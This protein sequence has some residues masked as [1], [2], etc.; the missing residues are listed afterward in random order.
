MAYQRIAIVGKSGS[1]K[2]TLA[3]QVAE[4][5]SLPH[6]ELDAIHCQANW[7]HP[8]RSEMRAQVELEL[9]S[10]P[11]WIADGNYLSSVQDIVW[12]RADTLIW[13]DYPLHV[14]L[15]RLLK[16]TYIRLFGTSAQRELWNGN[17]ETL[18]HHLTSGIW[19]NLFSWSTKM[20]Y[21]MRRDFP[22]LLEADD[23]KHLTVLRFRNSNETEKWLQALSRKKIE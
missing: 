16:R 7:T 4:K 5:L 6:I 11:R 23:F 12:S 10:K 17:H 9:S 8:P 22:P 3:R 14:A 19:N 2:T 13:L 20:H 21:Q 18:W 1:G 15:W